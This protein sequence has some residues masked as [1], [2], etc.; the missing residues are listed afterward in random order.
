MRHLGIGPAI[1]AVAAPEHLLDLGE[2]ERLFR[3]GDED[4]T[5]D[6]PERDLLEAVC[7]LVEGLRHMACG[8][9]LA[10]DA[11]SPGVIGADQYAGVAG[12]LAADAGAAVPTHVDQRAQ[13]AVLAAHDDR[14]LVRD[15]EQEKIADV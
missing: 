9:E 4:Q 13:R 8:A 11:V 1:G 14:A 12:L 15:L 2:P 5:L 10:V 6:D 3:K 7:R